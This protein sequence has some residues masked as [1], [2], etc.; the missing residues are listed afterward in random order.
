VD[1]GLDPGGLARQVWSAISAVVHP[2]R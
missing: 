2:S 1:G